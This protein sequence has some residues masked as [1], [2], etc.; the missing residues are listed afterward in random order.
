MKKLSL[1]F[2][3]LVA[4]CGKQPPPPPAPI[5]PQLPIRAVPFA[6][7][8]TNGPDAIR[9]WAVKVAQIPLHHIESLGLKP[10]LDGGGEKNAVIT[11]LA[12][13]SAYPQL[14]ARYTNIILT[15]KGGA[16]AGAIP[17]TV[18]TN[19]IS[20]IESTT[21]VDVLTPQPIVTTNSLPTE[22]SVIDQLNVI[23]KRPDMEK[24]HV[25]L[26]FRV[27]STGSTLQAAVRLDEFAGY[28]N[29]A[30]ILNSM[31]L[32]TRANLQTNEALLVMGPGH[33][34]VTKTVDRVPV[35]SAIPVL[36]RLFTATETHTNYHRVMLIV[37]PAP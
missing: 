25:G 24:V 17:I 26:N 10:L 22:T 15:S 11:N 34:N 9:K 31:T 8:Q 1:L 18:A 3:V 33:F 16:Y 4:A 13:Q 20:R 12:A 35:L 28:F 27:Q 6:A 5:P 21:G 29:E 7:E 14:A 36:G 23:V 2:V 32:G 19:L 30:P 37:V